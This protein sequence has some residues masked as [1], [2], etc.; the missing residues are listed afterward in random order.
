MLIKR[1]KRQRKLKIKTSPEFREKKIT[2]SPNKVFV[3]W[4]NRPIFYFAGQCIIQLL[5]VIKTLNDV[6]IFLNNDDKIKKTV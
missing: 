5:S 4:D 6:L 3:K 1:N 2:I